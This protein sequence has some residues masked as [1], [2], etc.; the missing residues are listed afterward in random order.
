MAPA[1]VAACILVLV[2]GTDP[3]AGL[4]LFPDRDRD[5]L[6]DPYEEAHGCLDPDDDSDRF[7][8]D[9]DHDG[10]PNG[11]D[12]RPCEPDGVLHV[13]TFHRPSPCTGSEHFCDDF[14]SRSSWNAS[15]EGANAWLRL[16]RPEDGVFLTSGPLSGKSYWHVGA[17]AGPS[18][19][20]GDGVLFPVSTL[21]SPPIDL[22]GATEPV[23]VAHLAG[24]SAQSDLLHVGVVASG[25]VTHLESFS[26][27][28]GYGTPYTADLDAFVGETIRLRFWFTTDEVVEGLGGWN[29]DDVIVAEKP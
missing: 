17:R 26:G 7:T 27:T 2:A 20:G 16:H 1:T 15:N 25:G 6:S 22:T 12:P 4:D 11:L 19:H 8:G 29:V 5:G 9:E 10:A 24:E 23:L 14:E 28:R 21:T 18:Y 3:A 13:D